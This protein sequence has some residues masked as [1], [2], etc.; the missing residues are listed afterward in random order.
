MSHRVGRLWD[1]DHVSGKERGAWQVAGDTAGQSTR[2]DL[3]PRRI[4]PRVQDTGHV[5]PSKAKSSPSGKSASEFAPDVPTG[6]Y[7]LLPPEWLYR[8]HKDFRST[9]RPGLLSCLFVGARSF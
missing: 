4:S 6:E 7:R 5:R 8:D 9:A 3:I 1:A 2:D